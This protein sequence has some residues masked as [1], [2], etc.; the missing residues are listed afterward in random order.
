M[1]RQLVL[2]SVLMVITTLVHGASTAGVLSTLHRIHAQR[3]ILRSAWTEATVIAGL[4]VVLL[5]AGLLEAAIWAATYVAVGAISG[6]EPALYFSTVTFTTLGYGDLVLNTEWRLLAGLQ[7]A[8][9]IVIFGWTTALIV[10][11]VQ[12]VHARRTGWSSSAE[13]G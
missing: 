7:A 11:I 1:L 9:G 4:V 10:A 12:R 5:L 3:W 8:N 13:K 6:A 2:G